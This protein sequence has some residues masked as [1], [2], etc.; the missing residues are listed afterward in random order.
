MAQYMNFKLSDLT[1]QQKSRLS[2]LQVSCWKI[3]EV[4]DMLG[5]EFDAVV[6]AQL[7]SSQQVIENE[8]D[9]I[10]GDGK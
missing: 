1:L 3:I 7:H 5:P 9:K 4:I 8:M 2:T 6:L 10:Y